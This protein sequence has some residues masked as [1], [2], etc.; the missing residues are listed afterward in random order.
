M[1]CDE[2]KPPEVPELDTSKLKG[3]LPFGKS[4]SDLKAPVSK[5][6]LSDSL[7][8][9]GGLITSNA[10]K[11]G[12]S[13][14]PDAIAG[15]I[16]D[17]IEGIAGSITSRVDSAVSGLSNLKDRITGFDPLAKAK[18]FVPNSPEE[19]LNDVKGKYNGPFAA[20]AARAAALEK[21]CGKQ[22]AGKA[23]AVGVKMDDKI[24]SK[25]EALTPKERVAAL[26]DPEVAKVQKEK[27]IA[28]VKEETK[29]ETVKTSVTINK[30]VRTVQTVTQADSVTTVSQKVERCPLSEKWHY[31]EYMLF[32]HDT[33]L[34][35]LS[36][37]QVETN[38]I[39]N[40]IAFP[41]RFP[42]PPTISAQKILGDTV[43]VMAYRKLMTM[44]IDLWKN[45]GCGGTDL[46]A[47]ISTDKSVA[48]GS[49]RY[50]LK[51]KY[52]NTFGGRSRVWSYDNAIRTTGTERLDQFSRIWNE[53][54]EIP[55]DINLNGGLPK[56]KGYE[57]VQPSTG[58]DGIGVFSNFS[59][60][61]ISTWWGIFHP[62]FSEL[63][64]KNA[65]ISR[66]RG[67]GED[68]AKSA[69]V[70]WSPEDSIIVSVPNYSENM[71]KAYF[72]REFMI[73]AVINY[74]D[75]VTIESLDYVG[76]DGV[77]ED[78]NLIA[79]FNL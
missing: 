62:V 66:E 28:E 43:H 74:D 19:T 10:K 57:N 68:Y 42:N 44:T 20:E 5:S 17:A 38:A 31:L 25:T 47:P 65:I 37:I 73:R 6:T 26:K 76:P 36:D 59:T 48:L 50:T 13:F 7:K 75:P 30:E 63:C 11:L 78:G 2:I 35:R 60:S 4:L 29:Q 3:K 51:E 23:S 71:K 49:W 40:H 15:K 18:S 22:F 45:N 79:T 72:S 53:E 33:M 34:R 52:P 56:I 14:S 70:E 8:G 39:I 55:E 21:D 1:G 16:G 46:N 24:K 41:S 77:L 12:D 54:F 67:W 58:A 61:S 64:K 32:L 9:A 27:I 69:Q